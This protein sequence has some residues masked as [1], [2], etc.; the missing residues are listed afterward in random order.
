MK[1]GG[2]PAWLTWLTH[3][4]TNAPT[5]MDIPDANGFFAESADF[6]VL[7]Q[8]TFRRRGSSVLLP[9][10]AVVIA[11]VKQ[12]RLVHATM[13]FAIRL[14]IAINSRGR[15]GD[16]SRHRRLD[17]GGVPR[18]PVSLDSL[19]DGALP[20]GQNSHDGCTSRA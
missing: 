9:P 14:L 11:T 18:F 10:E 13:V 3:F 7:S 8:G 1:N 6:Q 19:L 17:D 4:E 16:G 5:N 15:N 12:D 20:D 2:L